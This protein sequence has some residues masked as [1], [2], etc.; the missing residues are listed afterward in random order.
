[1]KRRRKKFGTNCASESEIEIKSLKPAYSIVKQIRLKSSET[2]T[3]SAD[4]ITVHDRLSTRKFSKLTRA[5]MI[6]MDFNIL[7]GFMDKK[8]KEMTW[9]I[10]TRAEKLQAELRVFSWE[11]DYGAVSRFVSSI[12]CA[13]RAMLSCFPLKRPNFAVERVIEV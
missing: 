2:V 10:T 13:F 11:F 9:K 5:L 8:K 12:F 7:C 4:C 6:L 1:M 3:K